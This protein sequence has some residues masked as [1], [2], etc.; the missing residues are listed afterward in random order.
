M[1]QKSATKS[2]GWARRWFALLLGVGLCLLV[3]SI[4][5]TDSHR[6]LWILIGQIS[7]AVGV[8]AVGIFEFFRREKQKDD[9]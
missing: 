4:G 5:E 8:L 1:N 2:K 6:S 7:L 9:P 3:L